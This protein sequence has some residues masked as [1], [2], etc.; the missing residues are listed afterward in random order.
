MVEGARLCVSAAV[1]ERRVES[2]APYGYSALPPSGERVLLLPYA[3]GTVC[4]GIL[5]EPGG[6]HPGEIQ[7]CSAG[8]ARIILKNNGE[9]SLNG[10]TVTPQGELIG[11]RKGE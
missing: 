4:A 3:Q 5:C 6:L 10:L 2:Y 9:I 11:G 1:E 7:I 8:G